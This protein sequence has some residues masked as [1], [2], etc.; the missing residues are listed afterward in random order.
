MAGEFVLNPIIA[1][2]PLEHAETVYRNGDMSDIEWVCYAYAWRNGACRYSNMLL[3]YDDEE[4]Y[5]I[6]NDQ[7]AFDALVVIK[8]HA[9]LAMAI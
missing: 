4:L 9:H 8:A 1:R 7:K 3:Q 6:R 2:M 5:A